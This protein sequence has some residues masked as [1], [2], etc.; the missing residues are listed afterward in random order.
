MILSTVAQSIGPINSK[1]NNKPA[2]WRLPEGLTAL[3]FDEP[4]W[5]MF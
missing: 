1:P 3:S 4:T 5:N 2:C